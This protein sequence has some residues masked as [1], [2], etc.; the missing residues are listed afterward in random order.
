MVV[1]GLRVVRLSFVAFIMVPYGTSQ[2]MV[3]SV[4]LC[5][6]YVMFVFVLARCLLL[7]IHKDVNR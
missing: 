3:C 2:N 5:V 6:D 1:C 4:M 7:L